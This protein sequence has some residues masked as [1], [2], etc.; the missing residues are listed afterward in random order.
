MSSGATSW[1]ERSKN[2][3]RRRGGKGITQTT[4]STPSCGSEVSQPFHTLRS[5][6]RKWGSTA[7]DSKC[8]A[9]G[10]RLWWFFAQVS[11]LSLPG[12]AVRRT[13]C[14]HAYGPAI[15]DPVPHAQSTVR[16]LRAFGSSWMRGSSPRM[17]ECVAG[18]N[19]GHDIKYLD[20][21]PIWF[22]S[23]SVLLDGGAS[24]RDDPEGGAGCGARRCGS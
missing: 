16:L 21:N 3:R 6:P 24:S 8:V 10:E 1:T 11:P 9:H 17:T 14:L 22:Y 4:Q 18:F 20:F 5:S 12:I 15:H 7:A 13:A 2:E 19:N 23:Y